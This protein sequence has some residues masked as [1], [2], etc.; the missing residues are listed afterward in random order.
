MGLLNNRATIHRLVCVSPEALLFP[1]I[2]VELYGHHYCISFINYSSSVQW[3]N[4]NLP[5]LLFNEH[6]LCA[7]LCAK[8]FRHVISLLP[9]NA[10]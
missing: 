9:S 8:H 3:S 7:R 5:L 2:A 1:C 4:D 10:D 6:L